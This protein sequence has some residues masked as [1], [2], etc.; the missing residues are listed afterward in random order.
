VKGYIKEEY[1]E[2]MHISNDQI[3]ELF[4]KFCKWKYLGYK[5]GGMGRKPNYID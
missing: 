3:N 4:E 2:G 5:F 1:F